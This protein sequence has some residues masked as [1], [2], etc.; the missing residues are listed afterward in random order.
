MSNEKES[1][2][3][4]KDNETGLEKLS[5]VLIKK[6]NSK[7]LIMKLGSDGFI[8][9]DFSKK[10]FKSQSFPAL[11]VNPL[12]VAGAGDSLLAVMSVGLS[13]K[14]NM[15]TTSA[16]ACCMAAIAVETMGNIPISKD[17]LVSKI[18]NVFDK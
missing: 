15:M 5:Q 8:A 1:R 16:I 4:L 12:D 10:I 17:K 2:I 7:R 6:T 11:S 13:C 3:A 14:Q 18:I 9:Y